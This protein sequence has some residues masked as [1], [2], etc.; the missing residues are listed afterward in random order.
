LC[1]QGAVR[2]GLELALLLGLG[3]DGLDRPGHD[4]RREVLDDGIEDRRRA[5]VEGGRGAEDRHHG[6]AEHALAQPA[7]EL[8]LGEGLPF[9]VLGHQLVV[10]LRHRLHQLLAQPIHVRAELGRDLALGRATVLAEH[11]GLP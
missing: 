4:R 3:I 11:E 5:P 6:A 2:I 8:L 1:R 7:L 10:G 9:Q